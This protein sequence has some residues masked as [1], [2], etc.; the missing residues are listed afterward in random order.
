MS[1]FNAISGATWLPCAAHKIQIAI[2][3]A[4]K[5]GGAL[6]LLDKCRRISRMFK[7]KDAVAGTLAKS[8]EDMGVD[9]IKPITMNATRWHSRYEMTK[10]HQPLHH[11]PWPASRTHQA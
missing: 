2:N 8:Q 5:N 6:P 10:H 9:S 3:N 7:N 11:K 4:W 1:L